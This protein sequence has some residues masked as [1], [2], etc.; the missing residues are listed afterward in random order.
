MGINF[1]KTGATMTAKEILKK[2]HFHFSQLD[3]L[4][5][6]LAETLEQIIDIDEEMTSLE[7]DYYLRT[8]KFPE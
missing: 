6:D 7:F 1:N 5:I 8:G 2:L 3:I 4:S